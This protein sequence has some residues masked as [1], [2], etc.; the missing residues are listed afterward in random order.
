MQSPDKL[1]LVDLNINSVRN[2]FEAFTYIIGNNIGLLLISETK[3]D[4]SFPISQFEM[5]CF[6]FPY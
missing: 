2:K 6:S 3:L 4:D 5:K 1:I